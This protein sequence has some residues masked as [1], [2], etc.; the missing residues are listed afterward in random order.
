MPEKEPAIE[1]C[2]KVI[3]KLSGVDINA[4]LFLFF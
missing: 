4:I 2:Q 3:E 1:G